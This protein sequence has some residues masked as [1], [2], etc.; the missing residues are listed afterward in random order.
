MKAPVIALLLAAPFALAACETT[1]TTTVV[2]PAGASVTATPETTVTTPSGTTV[3][4]PAT[5]TVKP[6]AAPAGR[7]DTCGAANYQQ[8]IGQKSPAISLP[9]G[10]VARDYRSGA[11]V[12]TDLNLER[13]NFEYDRAGKLVSVTCG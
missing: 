12:T 4:A 8:F 2:A 6:S 11:A 3:T 9:A 7:Q 5:V 1:K 10:T 13:L